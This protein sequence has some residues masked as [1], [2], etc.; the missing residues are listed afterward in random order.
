MY[1]L[2]RTV[3]E[4]KLWWLK[5]LAKIST[6]TLFLMGPGTHPASYKM[7]LVFF[8]GVKRPGR[9]VNHPHPSSSKV[10]E[11]VEL[12]FYSPS[13]HSWPVVGW[14]LLLPCKINGT[15]FVPPWNKFSTWRIRRHTPIPNQTTFIN[16]VFPSYITPKCNVFDSN[17]YVRAVHENTQ[18]YDKTS[19]ECV[20][21]KSS[22]ATSWASSLHLPPSQLPHIC[23]QAYITFCQTILLLV[24]CGLF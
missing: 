7:G 13:G 23:A 3:Q 6:I 24:E 8:L 15:Y 21:N 11:R 19:F 12:Y 18:C 4:T 14:M 20:D 10:K 5:I 17:N 2:P 16:A 9:G 22:M 1:F